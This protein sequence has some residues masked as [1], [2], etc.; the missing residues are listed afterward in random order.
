MLNEVSK[1][2]EDIFDNLREQ[3][4][5]IFFEV[6]EAFDQKI[7]LAEILKRDK[8]ILRSSDEEDFRKKMEDTL[9][10][11][12]II[13]FIKKD[14]NIDTSCKLIRKVPNLKKVA[15]KE[16]DSDSRSELSSASK[17]NSEFDI[18]DMPDVPAKG[19]KIFIS[20]YLMLIL[21]E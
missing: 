1:H 13:K 21:C 9:G 6:N 20:N 18:D 19:V 7:L 14:I 4:N 16:S 17:T 10:K 2:F 12:E 11:G 5:K 8:E 15:F 3:Q